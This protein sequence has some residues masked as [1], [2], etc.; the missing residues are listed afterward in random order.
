[1]FSAGCAHFLKA[2]SVLGKGVF[3]LVLKCMS[4]HVCIC[5]HVGGRAVCVPSPGYEDNGA[6]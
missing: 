3:T 4:V 6:S 1:M 2:N 5:A